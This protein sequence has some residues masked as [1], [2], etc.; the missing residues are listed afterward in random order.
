M[1]AVNRNKTVV[2]QNGIK[3]VQQNWFYL[4]GHVRDGPNFATGCPIEY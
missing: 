4:G 3:A 1:T 2:Q